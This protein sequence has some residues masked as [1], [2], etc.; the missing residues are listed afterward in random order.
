MPEPTI[1]ATLALLSE[2]FPNCFVLHPPRRRPLKIGI[3]HDLRAA[4]GGAVTDKEL[5]N[6]LRYYC[7]SIYYLAT[8]ADPPGIRFDLEGKP[9]GAVTPE[10]R[11]HARQQITDIRARYVNKARAARSASAQPAPAK[12]PA[13]PS[14]EPLTPAAAPR[15]SGGKRLSLQDLRE[16]AL[17]RKTRLKV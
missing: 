7:Y 3:Y 10:E 4:L 14:P 9:A 5:S 16:A 8:I 2:R 15:E 6:A 1:D 12:P 11:E 13:P 17:R